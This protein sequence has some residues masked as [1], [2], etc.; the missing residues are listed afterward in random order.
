MIYH[1]GFDLVFTCF[2]LS[3]FCCLSCFHAFPVTVSVGFLSASYF[4]SC[5]IYMFVQLSRFLQWFFSACKLY[6]CLSFLDF[7]PVSLLLTLLRANMWFLFSAFLMRLRLH[8]VYYIVYCTYFCVFSP[9]LWVPSFFASP[10]TWD[11]VPTWFSFLGIG[12]STARQFGEW[13]S[14]MP[15]PYPEFCG[16]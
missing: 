3:S 12:G 16:S 5:C 11:H 7:Q 15:Q 6:Y 4:F 8:V 2:S 13:I 1:G 9:F 14:I 10:P